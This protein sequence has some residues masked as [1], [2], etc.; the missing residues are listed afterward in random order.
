MLTTNVL[1]RTFWI[2]LTHQSD[3]QTIHSYGTAFSI[4][5][6]NKQYLITA[7]HVI[8]YVQDKDIVGIFHDNQWK[9]IDITVVGRGCA[10]NPETDVAVLATTCHLDPSC[11]GMYY[12]LK[13]A[14]AGFTLG[15]Q[16]YFCGFP[17]NLYT[18]I[19]ENNGYPVPMIKGALIS[20]KIKKINAPELFVLDGHN[21]PGFSGGPVAFQQGRGQVTE[22][23]IIGIVSSYHF[24]NAPVIYQNESTGQQE[25]T[26]LVSKENAGIILCPSIKQVIDMIENNPIGFELPSDKV[27]ELP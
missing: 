3:G 24:N 10:D 17:Y 25:V 6:K 15:Q 1:Q 11:P 21:N 7:S 26:K 9:P 27:T 4:D 16:V 23:Q 18:E 13:T 12:Q 19:Q 2:R 20:G 14:T 8:K 5:V 22:F